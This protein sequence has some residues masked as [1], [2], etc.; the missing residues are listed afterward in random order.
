LGNNNKNE[1][2]ITKTKGYNQFIT[3]KP[4]FIT[5][6]IINNTNNN[7]KHMFYF[8]YNCINHTM[9]TCCSKEKLVAI[10]LKATI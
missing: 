4:V 9:E 5:T 2:G 7:S 3:P 6:P 10:I 8:D 1:K